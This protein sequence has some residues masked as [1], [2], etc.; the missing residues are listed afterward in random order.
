MTRMVV[1]LTLTAVLGVSGFLAAGSVAGSASSVAGSTT[2][3]NSTVSLR[4]TKLG[5]I[6]VN[7]QNHTLYLF[8]KDKN[9]KSA[10]SGSCARFWPPLLSRSK[11]TAGPGVK[12]SLLGRTMRS[13]GNLQVT[14]NRHPLY[15]YAL[16]KQAGQ[17]KGQGSSA[18]GGKWWAVS[19]RGTAIVKAPTTT[20]T[21]A[22]TTGTTTTTSCPYPPCDG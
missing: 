18:S 12:P 17:T 11:P 9:G 1:V 10:C 5:L 8:A 7:S 21:T 6:L 3:A 2:G 15:T 13:N 4:K 14:Y 22:T 16:D 19:A 20:T